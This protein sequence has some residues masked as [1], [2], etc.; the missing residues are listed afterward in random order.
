MAGRIEGKVA[1]VTGAAS[2]IGKAIVERFRAEG[3]KVAAVDLSESALEQSHGEDRGVLR[4]A[5]DVALKDA[6]DRIVD[7]AIERFGCLDILINNAG[8]CDYRIVEETSD[9]IWDRTLAIDLTA[10][11][12]LSRRA[13]P[14]LIAGGQGRI[15]NTASIMA[16]R[17]YPSLV[18]YTS[19]KHG[20]AGLT[21]S[22]AVELGVHGITANYIMPGATLSGI[23]QPL[24]DSDETLRA[25]YDRMSVIGRMAKPHELAAAFL[26][27]ASDEASFITGH[28]LAVDGGA[29]LKM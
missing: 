8:I 18:A 15:I 24:I 16:E 3:A 21:K 22:L 19:A 9:E 29:L 7:A 17:P 1:I 12:R 27:L 23:T 6:P 11:F 14:H 13:V 26:F 20:V 2:G 4:I 25:V 5:Q 28:G 10:I